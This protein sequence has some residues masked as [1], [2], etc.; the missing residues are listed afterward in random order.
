MNNK[1]RN[2]FVFQHP[3]YGSSLSHEGIDALLASAA[4]EQPCKALFIG[5][6]IYNLM[7]QQQASGLA[8][9]NLAQN[10]K[11]LAMYEIEDVYASDEDV[12]QRQLSTEDF[13]IPVK[14]ITDSAIQQLFSEADVTH[15]F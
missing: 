1:T 14:L 13:C 6:G 9:R 7:K 10:L 2:L 5:D 11:A 15:S 3:P 8:K 4:F 12:M